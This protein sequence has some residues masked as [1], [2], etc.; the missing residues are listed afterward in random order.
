M[1]WQGYQNGSNKPI[2]LFIVLAS[3]VGVHGWDLLIPRMWLARVSKA[4]L[5]QEAP[6]F[7]A[8][9]PSFLMSGSLWDKLLSELN[10]PSDGQDS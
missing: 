3:V 5:P 2:V 10:V 8:L 6:A 4:L 7:Y 9:D 1:L